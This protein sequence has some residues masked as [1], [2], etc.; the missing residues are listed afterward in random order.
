ML[1]K[2]RLAYKLRAGL[3]KRIAKAAKKNPDKRFVLIIDEINRGNIAKI[4]GELITLIEDSRR[5]G[6]PDASQ[7]MLPYS[8]KTFGVPDNLYIV[9]TMNTADRSI[10]LL[11]T[12]LRRRFTFIETMPDSEHPL[13]SGEVDG[14]DCRKMLTAMNERIAALLDREHQIG[15]TYLLEVD[16]IRKLSDTFRNRIFPLLQEYFFDDWAKIRVVLGHNAFVKA[17]KV[18]IRSEEREI[19]DEDRFVYERL[20]DDDQRWDRPGEYRKIYGGETGG[21]PEDG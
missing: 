9:G 12:A 17:N 21:E 1:R 19:M 4:L 11:D 15:H 13:I 20:P 6:Q 5:L 18:D 2:G 8:G 3:F 10:Q 7:V 14:I 16:E